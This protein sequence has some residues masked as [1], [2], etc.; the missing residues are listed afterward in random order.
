M[1]VRM[2]RIY[3]P[4]RAVASI[5]FTVRINHVSVSTNDVYELYYDTFDLFMNSQ[6]PAILADSSRACNTY[7]NDFASTGQGGDLSWVRFYP[8][9][10]DGTGGDYFYVIKLPVDFTPAHTEAIDPNYCDYSYHR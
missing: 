3:N 2:A 10:K 7:T 4:S 5:P 9:R 6:T 8:R 1:K